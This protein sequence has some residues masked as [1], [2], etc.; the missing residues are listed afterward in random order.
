MSAASSTMGSALCRPALLGLVRL[1]VGAHADWQGSAPVQRQRIYYANHTSH[2]DTLVIVASL[3]PDLRPQTHPVA[4]LDYWGASVLRR[5][6]AVECLNAV[7]IYR[8]SQASTDPLEPTAE[9]LARGHSLILFPE[10]TRGG[11]GII[12]PFRSGLYN[13]ARRFPEAELVPVHLDNPSRVMPKGSLLI[14]PLIC[15][16]RFGAPVT[17]GPTEERAEFLSRARAALI[18]LAAPGR[19]PEVAQAL[20]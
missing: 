17:L 20:G 2:F 4:A 3:P 18:A 5:F 6:I 11:D 8:S 9:V 7:L 15:T 19:L 14:V 1:L 10:G 13:L 12:G 16:A